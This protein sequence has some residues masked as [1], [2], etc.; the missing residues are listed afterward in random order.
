[1]ASPP[2]QHKDTLQITQHY[3]HFTVKWLETWLF[4]KE[5]SLHFERHL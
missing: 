4:R 2:Q 1:M 3:I 5:E